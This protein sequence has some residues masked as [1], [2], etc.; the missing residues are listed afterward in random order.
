MKR[1]FDFKDCC[2]PSKKLTLQ[3][4]ASTENMQVVRWVREHQGL[5]SEVFL[6]L[7]NHIF[8]VYLQAFL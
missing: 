8:L 4:H 2:P 5:E 7:K 3:R 1:L 6:R